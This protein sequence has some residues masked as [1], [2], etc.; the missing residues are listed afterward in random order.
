MSRSTLLA[1][2]AILVTLGATP[3]SAQV[4]CGD[5][6]RIVGHLDRAYKEA[7]SGIGLGSNG[8]VV[9]LYTARTGSWTLL[10]TK[11]GATTCVIGSGEAWEARNAPAPVAGK[12]S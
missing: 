12:V 7:R 4:A 11:P 1:I 10:I 3:A 6:G 2:V 5:H 8:A 9:E